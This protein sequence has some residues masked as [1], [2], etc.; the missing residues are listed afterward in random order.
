MIR[1]PVPARVAVAGDQSQLADLALAA[2]SRDED[3]GPL[4]PE[5]LRQSIV[6]HRAGTLALIGLCLEHSAGGTVDGGDVLID[7]DAWH[8]GSALEAADDAGLLAD[9]FP[10]S[11]QRANAPTSAKKP[12]HLYAVIRIDFQIPAAEGQAAQAATSA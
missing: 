6:R 1:H 8:I 9:V 10:G 5:T 12:A 3:D 4:G 2:W 7:L 11:F